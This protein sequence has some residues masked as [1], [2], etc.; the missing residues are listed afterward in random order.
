MSQN[1]YDHP[2]FFAGYSQLPRQVHGLAGAPEWP[3]LRS[4]FPNMHGKRVVDLG[5]GFGWASRWLRENGARSA[6][7]IDL[8]E[9]MISRARELTSDA[10]IAYRTADLESLDLSEADFDFA[11]SSLTFHYIRDFDRLVSM[12]HRALTPESS[13]VFSIE[14][15]IFMAAVH[16]HW[17]EDEDGRKTWPVNSY[18]IEGERRTD[19][20]A[21]GVVKYHRRMGT[22]LNALVRAGFTIEK[23]EEFA[24]SAEQIK[25]MP[26]LEEELER[27]MMLLI[28][29][30]R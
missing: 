1:I 14:H 3:A 27:P 4:M 29:S 7:G 9:N 20:F 2:D 22:T 16:P 6:L 10:A 28:S 5:C 17:I 13:F 11:F 24:P 12:I 25:Q 18:A 26:A 19:W 15:P 21:K 8:S 30:K 23:V